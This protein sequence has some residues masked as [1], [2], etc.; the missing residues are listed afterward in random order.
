VHKAVV[1]VLTLG[2]VGGCGD[3]TTAPTP[4]EL[5]VGPPDGVFLNQ[6]FTAAAISFQ[7]GQEL[8]LQ[9]ETVKKATI[10]S[11]TGTFLRFQ[12]TIEQ[13]GTVLEDFTVPIPGTDF[14]GGSRAGDW[15]VHTNVPGHGRVDLTWS[16]T[17][18]W[19]RQTPFTA[20][21]SPTQVI[22]LVGKAVLQGPTPGDV[23]GTEFG[24]AI[25]L[26][27]LHGDAIGLLLLQADVVIFLQQR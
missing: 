10:G 18:V 9:V 2:L 14:A 3:T 8:F 19:L 4:E 26:D 1:V 24:Q 12:R 22:K 21:V 25:G 11:P 5:V 23:T 7:S 20:P 17:G 27:P 15:A 13:D 6:G 16:N